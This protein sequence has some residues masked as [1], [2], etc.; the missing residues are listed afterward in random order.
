M[1]FMLSEVGDMPI[2]GAFES[3]AHRL[4]VQEAGP[5][6][7]FYTPRAEPDTL[8]ETT[9]DLSIALH[10]CSLNVLSL[11]ESNDLPQGLAVVGKRALLKRQLL[12]KQLHVVAFQETRASDEC[13]QPDSDFIM[14]H[15]ACEARGCF[16]CALW[17]SKT[18]PVVTSQRGTHC[19]PKEACTVA[20]SG[21]RFIIVH[22]DLPGF[23]LTL[24]SAHAPRDGKRQLL[25]KD[26][27][28]QIGSVVSR[29]PSGAQLVV[30][31]DSNGHLGSVCS[32]AVG[33]AGAE[34]ENEAGHAFHRF[35][36][37]FGLA[38]P[39]T[40]ED[41]HSG[42]HWTWKANASTG[43]RLGYVA[44]PRESFSGALAS[45]VWDGF[46]HTHDVD[47]HQPVLLYCTLL[48]DSGPWKPKARYSAPR[49]TDSTDSGQL[50][51]FR[52]AVSILPHVDWHFDVDAHY[53]AFA[54]STLWCWQSC[55]AR[56]AKKGV[57]PFISEGTLAAFEHRK[58]L[59]QFL[60]AETASLDYVRKLAGLFAFWL[61]KHDCVPCC[62]QTQWLS[63]QLRK[64]RFCVAYAVCLLRRL[65]AFLRKAVRLD[66]ASFLHSLV[67]KVAGS[68]LRQ[69]KQL[70]AAVYRSFPLVR[71]KRRSGF[72]PLPFSF[73]HSNA[74][75]ESL[76]YAGMLLVSCQTS[77]PASV[78]RRARLT[79]DGKWVKPTYQLL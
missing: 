52:H 12:E 17:L 46:D 21:P 1:A 33:F 47:D 59:R 30:L 29:R 65:R 51:C 31:S 67:D 26:F 64:G 71:S 44:V 28:H 14:L 74:A 66:R 49:P 19:F 78:P 56:P 55:V 18:L 22:V 36:L 32:D 68:S 23:P 4:F 5:P 69:P 62:A 50:Q 7:S 54:R 16:G 9:A 11:R 57:Q 3:E 42:G 41:L 72:C 45:K 10:C 60:S 43:H 25:A 6:F 79:C 38:L 15:S 63:L 76:V 61:Q 48:R 2:L 40:F 53:A 77:S 70:F 35:L 8:D 20:A 34:A 24:V 27:W 73:I 37:D 13:V 58:C 75:S 39:S